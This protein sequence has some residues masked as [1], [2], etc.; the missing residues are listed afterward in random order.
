MFIKKRIRIQERSGLVDKK[1]VPLIEM[2]LPLYLILSQYSYGFLDVGMILMMIV[3]MRYLFV[4]KQWYIC[5]PMLTFFVYM[6]THDTLKMLFMNNITSFYVNSILSNCITFLIIILV[7]TNLNE[8]KLYNVWK[9]TGIIVIT[10]IFYHSVLVYGLGKP[11]L[12]IKVL[13][14]PLEKK[15]VWQTRYFRPRSFFSEP[16]A[17]VIYILPLL[18]LAIKR[19]KILFAGIITISIFL[20]TSTTGLIMSFFVWLY[21]LI[22]KGKSLK[23]KR[24]VI[25]SFIVI[26]LLMLTNLSI[27]NDTI[28][29]YENTKIRGNKRLTL[30]YD[31]FLGTQN[32]HKIFG[33]PHASIYEHYFS[34]EISINSGYIYI[35]TISYVLILYGIFG[36]LLYVNIFYKLFRYGEKEVRP[37]LLLVFL[38]I[39]GQSIFFN[40]YFTMQFIFLFGL[41]TYKKIPKLY[42]KISN[43]Q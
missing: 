7:S 40:S 14:I 34:D 6:M 37:Y 18:F 32:I 24:I 1:N 27:F 16:A 5:K 21:Y 42:Q 4:K 25:F 30:G 36:A 8:E 31:I 20:S 41:S 12:P 22:K 10:G 23:Y 17:Y 3:S 39:F 13:P 19:N 38:S 15:L 29:K 11:V 9:V 35:N 33:V 2:F 26:F 28:K 43:I